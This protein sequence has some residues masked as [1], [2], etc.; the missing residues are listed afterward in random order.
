MKYQ[1]SLVSTMIGRAKNHPYR[2]KDM[3]EAI[4]IFQ[5]WLDNYNKSKKN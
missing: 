5:K 1:V 2:N 3:D 4:K